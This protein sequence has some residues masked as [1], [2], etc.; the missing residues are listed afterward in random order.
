VPRPRRI[1]ITRASSL[2]RQRHPH[3]ANVTGPEKVSSVA[4]DH[5]AHHTDRRYCGPEPLLINWAQDSEWRQDRPN[6]QFRCGGARLIHEC[7]GI[8]KV[9]S[10]CKR[11]EELA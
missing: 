4:S 3:R 1:S 9:R 11:V 2:H 10:F 7:D 6:N 5:E 8:R